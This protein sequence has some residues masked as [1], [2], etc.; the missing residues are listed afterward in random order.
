MMRALMLGL[1]VLLV[2]F[3]HVAANDCLLAGATAF[4][5]W[6]LMPP[7]E[8]FVLHTTYL[9]LW[10]FLMLRF[11]RVVHCQAWRLLAFLG[12]TA[13]TSFPETHQHT[14]PYARQQSTYIAFHCCAT[15]AGVRYVT[16]SSPDARAGRNAMSTS[17]W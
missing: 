10:G 16:V 7:G 1:M 17:L 6:K 8:Q 4:P 11:Q 13:L 9:V 5:V 14:R 3:C 15:L 12:F 2:L